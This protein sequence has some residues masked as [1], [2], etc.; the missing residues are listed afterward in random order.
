MGQG[1]Y[2]W[3]TNVFDEES[4]S[5]SSVI[6]DDLM[7]LVE[8]KIREN[9][10]IMWVPR[11]LTA[12]H[13]EKRFAI[14]WDFLIRYE[15]EGDGMLSRTVT[16]DEKWLSHIDL[17]SKQQSMELRYT[18][19]TVKIKAKQTLSKRKVMAKV[20]WVHCGVL[21]VDFMPQG[22]TFNSVPTAQLYGSSEEQCKTNGAACCQKV[23]CSSHSSN[24][25]G[26]NRIF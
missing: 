16:G 20:F 12:E 6:T 9:K 26:V 17:E 21:L 22:T 24:D 8:T 14:S 5:R 10:R 1:V 2:R 25:S 3:R 19:F 7:L 11:L 18:S 23:F 4:S 13:K 15:E